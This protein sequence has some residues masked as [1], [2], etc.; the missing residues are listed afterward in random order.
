MSA[1]GTCAVVG[2]ERLPD[3]IETVLDT[4]DSALVRANAVIAASDGSL[5]RSRSLLAG[6]DE[7]ID[8]AAHALDLP[9]AIA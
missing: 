9:D 4:G 7:A 8:R 3:G 1:R 6:C 5:E 2:V